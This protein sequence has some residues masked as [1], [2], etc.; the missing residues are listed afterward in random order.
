MQKKKKNKI[1]H[2]FNYNKKKTPQISK[3]VTVKTKRSW[4]D[5]EEIGNKPRLFL[6][7]KLAGY[8]TNE[9]ELKYFWKKEE[10]KSF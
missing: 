1:Q 3:R 8:V 6:F 5:F 2:F 7:Q 9:F 4:F 10:K